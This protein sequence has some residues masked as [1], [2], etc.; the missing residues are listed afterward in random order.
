MVDDN[1]RARDRDRRGGARGIDPYRTGAVRGDAKPARRRDRAAP[2]GVEPEGTGSRRRDRD[3]NGKVDL[4]WEK[5][6]SSR[7]AFAPDPVT[8]GGGVRG[9]GDERRSGAGCDGAAVL[10]EEPDDIGGRSRNRHGRMV[11]P[12]GEAI[13]TGGE[14]EHVIPCDAHAAGARPGDGDERQKRARC[15]RDQPSAPASVAHPDV[16][17]ERA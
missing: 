8:A 9:D 17:E 2:A 10:S 5:R 16:P 13:V 3:R 12:G 11:R 1:R 15:R 14:G 7:R 6:G 4:R